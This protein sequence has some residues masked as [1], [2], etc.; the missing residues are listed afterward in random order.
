[1]ST[2]TLSYYQRQNERSWQST[3][4]QLVTLLKTWYQRS[5]QRQQLAQLSDRQLDDIG[6]DRAAAL[7]E[8]AKPFWRH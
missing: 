6:L 7:A 4:G 2:L 1:M 3:T 8:A 5:R